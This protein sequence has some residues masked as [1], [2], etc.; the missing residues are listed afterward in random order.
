MF[1]FNE[2]Y[3]KY[4]SNGSLILFSAPLIVADDTD[5]SVAVGEKVS[6]QV[7]VKGNPSPDV[8]W[9]INGQ[10]IK[11]GDVKLE[12]DRNRHRLSIIKTTT[13]HTGTYRV[14][15]VNDWGEDVKDMVLNVLGKYYLK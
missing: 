1:P 7:T 5:M 8:V 13:R 11:M 15:A 4:K 2:N 6:L 9:K 10:E 12:S 3:H 14:T